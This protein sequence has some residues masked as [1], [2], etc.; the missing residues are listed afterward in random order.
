M[1]HRNPESR[2]RICLAMAICCLAGLL[3]YINFSGNPNFY[4]ADMYTDMVYAQRA[5]ESGSI[6]PDGWAFGNQLY[7]VA[8]PNLAALFWGLTGS[9]RLAMA[10]ASTV[11]TLGILGSAAWM[12]K[13]FIPSLTARLAGTLA[14]LAVPL[15]RGDPI[16]SLA[17]WQLLY[18]LCSYYAC[19]VIT[20]CLSFGCYLRS[21][22]MKKSTILL[23][24]LAG[25]LAYG[26]GIGSFRQTAVM[27]LP[28]IVLEFGK[29]CIRLAK[30]EPLWHRSSGI[31]LLLTVC[32]VLGLLTARHAAAAQTEIFGSLGPAA[33]SDFLS[34][35]LGAFYNA[36]SLIARRPELTI[37][38]GILAAACVGYALWYANRHRLASLGN[39]IWLLFLSLGAIG[40]AQALTTMIV[41]DT[42]YFMVYV[43]VAVLAAGVIQ[44]TTPRI[45]GVVAACLVLFSLAVGAARINTVRLN[46]QEK[47]RPTDVVEFLTE[48][49]ITTI[50]TGWNVGQTVALESDG[51]IQVGY[52]D[53]VTFQGVTY[54]CDQRIFDEDPAHVAYL[55]SYPLPEDT[56]Y[57][58]TLLGEFPASG[59]W[60]YT[61]EENLMTLPAEVAK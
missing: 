35:V 7:A 46:I 50:Y 29:F 32:N 55:F 47:P 15:Y 17:G 54:L 26:T 58:V 2:I 14:L 4:C 11:M 31:I 25:I 18:T 37:P 60:V 44:F 9:H 40:A 13:P 43:L 27:I 23:L 28:M 52:W 20:A 16:A 24:I 56:D 39:C 59:F 22:Q 12:M 51:R 1:Q 48:Q 6:F 19:Y 57:P 41:R 53:L 21:E 45:R 49:D 34:N 33:P 38:E 5:W 8:T 30:K 42:Y 61:A 3:C 10:L 36:F